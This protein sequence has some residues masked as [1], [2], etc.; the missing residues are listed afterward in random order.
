LTIGSN[1]K[2]IVIHTYAYVRMYKIT[3]F[4]LNI[5]VGG[6]QS[7]FASK[8]RPNIFNVPITIKANGIITDSELEEYQSAVKYGNQST[9]PFH[10]TM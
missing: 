5:N 4:S 3:Q 7:Y 8:Y 1:E 6:I 9:V 2:P 10:Y